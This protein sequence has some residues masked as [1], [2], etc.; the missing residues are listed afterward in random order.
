MAT[1]TLALKRLDDGA[2]TGYDMY[3]IWDFQAIPKS[4]SGVRTSSGPD[5]ENSCVIRFSSKKLILTFA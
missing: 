2:I 1:H 5:F 3:R 4:T